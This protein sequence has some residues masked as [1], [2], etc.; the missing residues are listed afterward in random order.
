M[1]ASTFA[2]TAHPLSQSIALSLSADY[3]GAWDRY[4]WMHEWRAVGFVSNAE[5]P[6]VVIKLPA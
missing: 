1:N 4:I 3:N 2:I 6:P 5:A